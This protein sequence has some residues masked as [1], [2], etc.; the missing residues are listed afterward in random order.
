MGVR[1]LRFVVGTVALGL[2]LAIALGSAGV[3]GQATA[4]GAG[5]TL[6]ILSGDVSVRHGGDAF[7]LAADG[8]MVNEG[9][10]VRTGADGRAVLTYFEG[11]SVTIEPSTELAIDRATA[12]ADGG[13]VVVMTQN[14]GRTW[15]VVTKLISGSSKYEVKTPASTASVRG[16]AFEVNSAPDATTV[17]TTEGTVV[18]HV[19]DPARPGSTVD[20]P[21]TAGTMQTQSRNA[22]PEPAR[23][24]PEPQ[25]KVTVTVGATNTLVVDTLG[26]SNG[27]TKDGKL[28]VQTPGAQVKR[29]GDKI[30]ITLPDLPDGRLATRVEKKDDGDDGDVDVGA[31]IEENGRTATVN[32]AA[33]SDGARKS[34]GFE[35][36]RH[37]GGQTEGRSLSDAETQTL[38]NAKTAR[39]RAT[40]AASPVP[41]ATERSGRS[42]GTPRP[43]ATP[44]QSAGSRSTES[45]RPSQ[46]PSGDGTARPS[47]RSGDRQPSDGRPED[48]S[49]GSHEGLE[50]ALRP[51]L[52]GFIPVSNRLPTI[53]TPTRTPESRRSD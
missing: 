34:A 3:L 31:T 42:S 19:D 32:D 8:D 9:D 7:A 48:R 53:P 50:S 28:V 47:S 10:A 49:N 23:K 18:A 15:H 36:A 11:S 26:R 51:G 1:R 14:I 17:S 12:L 5:T 44:R 29:D 13:T 30:V 4:F 35:I 38:P 41:A 20:V 33:R 40:P 24:A 2:V 22:A 21:V 6:T 25:R 45:A 52:S 16:T 43:S 46:T 39:P 37:T 27:L